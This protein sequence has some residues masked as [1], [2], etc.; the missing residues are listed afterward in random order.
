MST[1]NARSGHLATS[2]SPA[3]YSRKCN[4][5]PL[6]W[7][8]QG[9]SSYLFLLHP[10]ASRSFR[11]I[12]LVTLSAAT[13]M[14]TTHTYTHSHTDTQSHTYSHTHTHIL[15]YIKY[16]P[17]TSRNQFPKA[18]HFSSSSKRVEQAKPTLRSCS[19]GAVP[20]DSGSS[21]RWLQPRSDM[22][23]YKHRL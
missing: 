5:L 3:N 10:F 6:L 7:P 16:F 20:P 18:I 8:S 13:Q 23:V 22:I 2:A 11:D 19:T 21:S 1:C 15:S 4:C 14:H 17:V 12:G 9:R